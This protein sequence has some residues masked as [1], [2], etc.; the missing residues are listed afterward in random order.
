MTSLRLLEQEVLVSS[1]ALVELCWSCPEVSWLD[2]LSS[3]GCLKMFVIW[4][5]LVAQIAW[6]EGGEQQGS[7]A[8][9]D[10][11]RV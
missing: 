2:D 7:G 11:G 1:S 9:K 10:R 6:H 8:A 3:S 4:F 5:S